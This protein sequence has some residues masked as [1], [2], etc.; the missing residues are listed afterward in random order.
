MH[1]RDQLI[2][3]FTTARDWLARPRNDFS[4]SSWTDAAQALREIDAIIAALNA[5]AP[6]DLGRM[7]T[8]L[9]PTGPIQEVSLSS[10]WSDAFVKLA[11]DFDSA[12]SAASP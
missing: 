11:C 12:L 9:A 7:R 1:D 8:L 10:G 5:G 2:A 3:V 4:W 6:L